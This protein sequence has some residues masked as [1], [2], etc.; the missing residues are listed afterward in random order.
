MNKST[1]LRNLIIFSTISLAA[2]WIGAWVNTVVPSPSLQESLGILVFIMFPFLA[3]FLLRGLGG[4]GWKD[5][6][7][8]LNLKGNWGWYLLSLLMYPASILLT[9]GLGAVFGAVS[10][11]GLRSQGFGALLSAIGLGFAMSLMKNIGEEFAWRGYLTP[12]FKALG[13]GDF[14]NHM[15]TGVIWGLWHVPYWLF[16][17]RP[18]IINEYSSL[19]VTGFVVMGL[20]GIFPTA[21][22]YGELRMKTDS[23]WPAFLAHNAINALSPQLVMMGFVSLKPNSELILSPGLDGLLMMAFSWILGIWMLRK[24]K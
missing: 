13:L 6:G 17:L 7:L 12:R 10:F 8:R 18:A 2:G 22:I 3:V 5:F 20:V 9:L 24:T 11:D 4:D 23:L 19:G 21:L 16:M 1:T 15:L 14:A